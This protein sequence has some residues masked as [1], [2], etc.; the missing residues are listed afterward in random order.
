VLRKINIKPEHNDTSKGRLNKGRK[1]VYKSKVHIWLK[2]YVKGP[3]CEINEC[4]REHDEY[5]E[6]RKL[7][8]DF[9]SHNFNVVNI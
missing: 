7:P 8:I 9:Q 5:F 1:G 6:G 4:I 3:Y 2:I